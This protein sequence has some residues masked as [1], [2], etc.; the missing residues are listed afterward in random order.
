[1]WEK[2]PFMIA[3]K[4]K[5]ILRKYLTKEVRDLYNEN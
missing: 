3:S 2:I 5:K 1:M 4:K